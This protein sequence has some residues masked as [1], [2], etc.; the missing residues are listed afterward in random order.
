[1]V[2]LGRIVNL[3]G[4]KG[5][6]KFKPLARTVEVLAPGVEIYL[7]KESSL[8]PFSIESITRSKKQIVI[9]LKGIN[10]AVEALFAL[11]QEVFFPEEKLPPLAE[12]E[13]YEYQLIGA[14][15]RTQDQQE[16]GQ[17]IGFWEI[18]EK[19]LMVVEKDKKE[20]LIPFEQKICLSIDLENKVIIVDPP[21]G[22]LNLNEI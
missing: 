8:S 7:K 13:F 2:V 1:M 22:L 16:I 12:G 17:V 20:I 21:E 3:V 9:K 4:K 18:G 5:E 11:G 6:L 14:T 15:V 19:T 10:S